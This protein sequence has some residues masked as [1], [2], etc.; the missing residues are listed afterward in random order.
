DGPVKRNKSRKI[1]WR[2]L[3][4]RITKSK[5]KQPESISAIR[6]NSLLLA[7]QANFEKG[8]PAALPS[9]FGSQI[10][11]GEQDLVSARQALEKAKQEHLQKAR[12]QKAQ[13]ELTRIE[14]EWIDVQDELVKVQEELLKARQRVASAHEKSSKV[15]PA[16]ELIEVW[17]V[18]VFSRNFNSY[19]EATSSEEGIKQLRDFL[20]FQTNAAE[21]ASPLTSP[22]YSPSPNE[23]ISHWEQYFGEAI[24]K[25]MQEEKERERRRHFDEIAK[26]T[27]LG[28][29]V[30]NPYNTEDVEGRIAQINQFL[31]LPEEEQKSKLQPVCYEERKNPEWFVKRMK[32]RLTELTLLKE[33]ENLGWVGESLLSDDAVASQVSG[34]VSK[35]ELVRRLKNYERELKANEE[36]AQKKLEGAEAQLRQAPEGDEESKRIFDEASFEY[37]TAVRVRNQVKDIVHICAAALASF[38][39]N[40]LF[41]RTRRNAVTLSDPDRSRKEVALILETLANSPKGREE[42]LAMSEV[43]KQEYLFNNL[44]E[45]LNKLVQIC[46]RVKAYESQTD[47]QRLDTVR[48]EHEE[49][50]REQ[51]A[52]LHVEALSDFLVT[53]ATDHLKQGIYSE[54]DL[55]EAARGIGGRYTIVTSMPFSKL[56]GTFVSKDRIDVGRQLG[57]ALQKD[58]AGSIEVA[59]L[60]VKPMQDDVN[61][62]E[63]ETFDRAKRHG[64]INGDDEF[65]PRGTPFVT[66]ATF[67]ANRDK[68]D[69]HLEPEPQFQKG[70][71]PEPAST[72]K[73]QS[74]KGGEQ[75]KITAAQ[76]TT[77]G[78]GDEAEA[79]QSLKEILDIV[80]KEHEAYTREQFAKLHIEVMKGDLIKRT[81]DHL[82]A[83][84]GGAEIA[85]SDLEGELV[86]KD[87]TEL[88]KSVVE[89][90]QKNDVGDIEAARSLVKPMQDYV[91][92][93]QR[94]KFERAKRYGAIK[95]ND[96]FAPREAPFVSLAA[97]A[98][99]HEKLRQY[100][101]KADSSQ[102]ERDTNPRLA[103]AIESKQRQVGK[104]LAST[105]QAEREAR[106]EIYQTFV[107][108][109]LRVEAKVKESNL[110]D[111]TWKL[112]TT[113]DEVIRQ[114]GISP[115]V[116]MELEIRKDKQ[117]LSNKIEVGN[118][119]GLR[120][121]LAIQSIGRKLG[122]TIQ[123]DLLQTVEKAKK[124][125]EEKNKTPFPDNPTVK[126]L[127]HEELGNVSTYLLH[128]D[129][130][131]AVAVVDAGAGWS[132][133]LMLDIDSATLQKDIQPGQTCIA[134]VK[135]QDG[136]LTTNV[137]AKS[138]S[139]SRSSSL[140]SNSRKNDHGR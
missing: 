40:D 70:A 9:S 139:P 65:M 45:G 88:G 19:C 39:Q 37:K 103:S 87:R 113:S 130:K 84:G 115:L 102:F 80:R 86:S 46:N 92:A 75:P 128:R 41:R 94:E 8:S 124:H 135:M 66:L 61:A 30:V 33:A 112:T 83:S 11:Q 136:K 5:N 15:V 26:V 107:E 90:L 67:V 43:A 3:W 38:N 127:G 54:V 137:N 76:L 58:A 14:Q 59:R 53:K 21:S 82:G 117:W 132:Q 24:L 25:K 129:E 51:F 48:K 18:P 29:W 98:A 105:N 31:K 27:S 60:L 89:A 62:H 12:L 69:R 28:R 63:R 95:G 134:S 100:L 49:Y 56:Q 4:S 47:M 91:H 35:E 104:Q 101:Q 108:D 10:E 23:F 131:R 52:T 72:N 50:T 73:S 106:Q 109:C 44:D 7:P 118:S 121:Q 68:H 74:Y 77:S 140:R 42:L 116:Q 79:S 93:Q 81:M 111:V 55:V 99:R 36:S 122:F 1:W 119:Y 64:G 71:K 123:G 32:E 22:R 6:N 97:F 133:G 16:T 120:D 125:F 20:R 114:D 110:H 34:D 78:I 13:Q 96:E 85:F 138:S 17:N 126:R 2:R 57:N